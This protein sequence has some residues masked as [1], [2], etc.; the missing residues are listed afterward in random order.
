MFPNTPTD[1]RNGLSGPPVAEPARYEFQSYLSDDDD[2]AALLRTAQEP[3]PAEHPHPD[4]LMSAHAQSL[5]M[6]VDEQADAAQEQGQGQGPIGPTSPSEAALTDSANSE[7][8]A[9]DVDS[10]AV[11]LTSP[12]RHVA[13]TAASSPDVIITRA[14]RARP[15]KIVVAVPKI[16]KKKQKT[17]KVIDLESD[18]ELSIASAPKNYSPRRLRKR[19]QVS[20]FIIYSNCSLL[21]SI[22]PKPHGALW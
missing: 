22:P 4:F 11:D 17:Y 5:E 20:N 6:D 9:M 13:S 14:R 7:A 19:T 15:V 12:P 21:S 10:G 3:L 16:S 2:E 18:D 1:P 8:D